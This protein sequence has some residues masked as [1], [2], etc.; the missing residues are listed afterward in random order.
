MSNIKQDL[1][2][3]RVAVKKIKNAIL[4]SRYRTAESAN[5][6]LLALYYSV[7]KYISYNTRTNKWGTGAI[8]TISTQLQGEISGL[9]GFSP[10]N[11]KNMRIF[12]EQWTSELEPNRQTVTA[13]L[14]MDCDLALIRQLSSAELDDVKVSAFRRVAFSHH[15][16]IL[17]KC[18]SRDERWY[19]IIRCAD[20]FWSYRTLI[21][22]LKADDYTAYGNLPN[23]FSLTIHN[24]ETAKI[25]IRS[26]RDE[27]LLDYINIKEPDNYDER[28]V[29]IAIVAEIKKFIM[30]A[31]DGF[32]FIGNQY[33]L[34]VDEEEFFID[35]LFFERNLQ[36]LVAFELKKDKFH[37]S[38]LGQL[39][40]Y[41]SALDKYVRKPNE[42]KTIGILLCESKKRSIVELAVQDYNKPLGVATYQL[43]TDIPKQYITLIPVID[44]VQQ[45]LLK[46]E[47]TKE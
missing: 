24:E 23:N 25:A 11:M 29:E 1:S 4:Q 44:G 28:D 15:I 17:R 46:N 47:N 41:L 19:Y 3:Y 35:M 38:D 2:L 20:E 12:F 39:S 33:R 7:G 30:S 6:D 21:C 32:C 45:I 26:F 14:N 42:N 9:R 18:K 13:D 16:E 10:S 43:G 37:P 36:C 31:G 27:Y 22:H 40:F 34:I 5:T 8:E